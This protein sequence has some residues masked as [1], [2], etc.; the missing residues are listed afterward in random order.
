MKILYKKSTIKVNI[1]LTLIFKYMIIE[2]VL[3]EEAIV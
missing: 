2:L 1:H 3:N